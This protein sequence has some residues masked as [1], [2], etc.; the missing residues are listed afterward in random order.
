MT[1][2]VVG[3]GWLNKV[4]ITNL[5]EYVKSGNH[6]HMNYQENVCLIITYHF[7]KDQS[8]DP[9][10]HWLILFHHLESSFSVEPTVSKFSHYYVLSLLN[11]FEDFKFTGVLT[12][13]LTCF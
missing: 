13:I 9:Y 11:S 5:F 10:E 8:N 1:L 2:S 7:M 6:K 4:S 12:A 3:E